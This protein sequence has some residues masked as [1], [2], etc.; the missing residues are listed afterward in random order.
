VARFGATIPEIVYKA[1]I[2][3]TWVKSYLDYLEEKGLLE[4]SGPLYKPT[5][6]GKEFLRYYQMVKE[7]VL[8]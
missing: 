3:F 1:D 6:R 2:N 4:Y 7:T 8:T 5:E